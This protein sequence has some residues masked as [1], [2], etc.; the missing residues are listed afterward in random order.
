MTRFNDNPNP[1]H[2]KKFGILIKPIIPSRFYMHK[3]GQ[4][5]ST[6]RPFPCEKGNFKYRK[7]Y[8]H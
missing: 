1:S 4:L 2:T 6:A 5:L 7:T 3:Q 8:L